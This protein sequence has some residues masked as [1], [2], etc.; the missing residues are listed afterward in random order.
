MHS[1]Q[2]LPLILRDVTTG[3]SDPMSKPV[4]VPLAISG[5][6]APL[7]ATAKKKRK[8]GYYDTELIKMD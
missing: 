1:P 3:Q 4:A 7:P 5:T 6:R 8:L 2:S